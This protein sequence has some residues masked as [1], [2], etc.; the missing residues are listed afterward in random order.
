M[1]LHTTLLNKQGSATDNN[2][3]CT[4]TQLTIKKHWVGGPVLAQGNYTVLKLLHCQYY[5]LIM[6]DETTV[7]AS[8]SFLGFKPL[9]ASVSAYGQRMVVKSM[10]S[11]ED[12]PWDGNRLQQGVTEL[13][14][15]Q[16]RSPAHPAGCLWLQLQHSA[17][18]VWA[19]AAYRPLALW[20]QLMPVEAKWQQQPPTKTLHW[21]LLGGCFHPSSRTTSSVQRR[22]PAAL[23]KAFLACAF[24]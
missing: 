12:H 22:K 4:E 13:T 14:P 15:P 5:P 19:E 21:M 23:D 1:F 17:I 6:A 10:K 16:C 8:H 24:L 18:S 20:L 7:I 11:P 3:R 2:R 9:W